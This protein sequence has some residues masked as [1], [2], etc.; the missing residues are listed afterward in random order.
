M[1]GLDAA[2]K[3]LG[4]SEAELHAQL[5]S[6]KSLADVA[7][8]RNKPVDGLKAAIEAAVK[9]DLDKAV[10]DKRLTRAQADEIL[11]ELHDHLD[12]IVNRKHQG[13]R[14]HP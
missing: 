7:K 8:A 12:E 6:G 10:G 5:E 9:S 4:L 2:A 11:S 3:Y 1:A 14:H 13:W